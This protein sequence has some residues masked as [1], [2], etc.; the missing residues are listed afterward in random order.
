MSMKNRW[1]FRV[2][3]NDR[4]LSYFIFSFNF[5]LEKLR[6]LLSVEEMTST[7]MMFVFITLLYA[8]LICLWWYK[9]HI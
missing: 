2:N 5:I 1:S 6:N 7:L 8:I 9:I 3:I 4:F